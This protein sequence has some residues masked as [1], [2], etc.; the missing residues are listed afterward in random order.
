MSRPIHVEAKKIVVIGGSVGIILSPNQL[1]RLGWGKGS[2]CWV[3]YHEERIELTKFSDQPK[4]KAS[5]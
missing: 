3:Q 1:L 2:Y 4:K 5:K